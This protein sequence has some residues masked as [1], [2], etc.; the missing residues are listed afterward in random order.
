[1]LISE[2]E[3]PAVALAATVSDLPV[4]EAGMRTR[5]SV[6]CDGTALDRMDQS[7]NFLNLL[8]V[9]HLMLRSVV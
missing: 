6:E 5:N 3:F 9:K 1:V 7:L 8:P 2:F 4:C